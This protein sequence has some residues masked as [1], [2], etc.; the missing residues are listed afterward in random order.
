MQSILDAQVDD[1]EDSA[2]PVANSWLSVVT[3]VQSNLTLITKTQFA[4]LHAIARQVYQHM[5]GKT[6][7]VANPSAVDQPTPLSHSSE[8]NDIEPLIRMC[9]SQ[10]TRLHTVKMKELERLNKT[11][12]SS[13]KFRDV[14]EQVIL[15][16][17]PCL[18]K[19]GKD[20]LLIKPILPVCDEDGM[21][22]PCQNLFSFL[23]EF[24][25]VARQEINYHILHKFGELAFKSMQN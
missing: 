20:N 11:A 16:E 6:L 2:S 9:G 5:H 17:E 4:M 13:V 19:D 18:T 15:I 12:S 23:R 3:T 25:S 8:A 22:F 24:D 10:L 21:C 14:E 1:C 7:A